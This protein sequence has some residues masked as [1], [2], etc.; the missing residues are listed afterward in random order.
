MH[1]KCFMDTEF[2]LWRADLETFEETSLITNMNDFSQAIVI[3][4]KIKLYKIFVSLQIY[5]KL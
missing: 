4:K 1:R 5:L 3:I 2:L